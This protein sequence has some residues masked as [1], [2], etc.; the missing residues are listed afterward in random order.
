MRFLRLTLLS[1]LSLLISCG[2]AESPIQISSFEKVS[3]DSELG[4]IT[5]R[6]QISAKKDAPADYKIESLNFDIVN[7]KLKTIEKITTGS[8]IQKVPST[9]TTAEVADLFMVTGVRLALKKGETTNI[10]K[11]IR[12]QF[13]E[14]PAAG[15]ENSEVINPTK[16]PQDTKYVQVK[17]KIQPVDDKL[18]NDGEVFEKSEYLPIEFLK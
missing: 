14:A 5:F 2:S 16:L 18:A 15:G 7:S 4:I 10:S 17:A 11:Q 1:F 6:L 12:L 3:G 13:M 8:I 9:E